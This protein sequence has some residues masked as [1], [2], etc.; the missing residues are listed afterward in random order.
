MKL[1]IF[2]YITGGGYCRESIPDSLAAEGLLMLN[3]LLRDC[4]ELTEVDIVLLLDARMAG[5]VNALNRCTKVIEVNQI[6]DF[7]AI[8]EQTIRE[9]DIVWPVAPEIDDILLNITLLVEKQ[10][11]TLLVSGSKAVELTADKLRTYKH[12]TD[13]NIQS[14]P[15]KL[16]TLN[17]YKH[18]GRRV[19]KPINGMGCEQAYCI[20]NWQDWQAVK[21]DLSPIRTYVE[22]PFVEGQPKS[23]SCLF[24]DGLGW[25]ICVNVQ[26]IDTEARQF[27]LTACLVNEAV[28]QERYQALIANIARAMPEL[29]G[30][31]GID[32]IET[33][34]EIQVLEINPRLTSSY[35]GV[36]QALGINVAEQVLSML[37]RAPALVVKNM[38]TIEVLMKGFDSE[39]KLT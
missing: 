24:K 28:S 7:I 10:N 14:V 6:D 32:I 38:Q 37:I 27:T 15:T 21:P 35:A 20:E 18:N 29:W 25:L 39:C 3:A 12:L 30:Y 22:Q 4:H 26:V 8:L 36:Y 31:V 5:K 2:E 16:F 19:I 33:G 1:L 9:C 17:G 11:K 23:L 34:H 13:H